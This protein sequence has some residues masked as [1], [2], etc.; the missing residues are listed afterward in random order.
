ML[1]NSEADDHCSWGDNLGVRVCKQ[2]LHVSGVIA[3]RSCKSLQI[4]RLKNRNTLKLEDFSAG[5][6]RRP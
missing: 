1:D 3:G 5:S 2:P 4:M 6:K